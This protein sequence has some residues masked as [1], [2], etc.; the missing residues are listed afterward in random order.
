MGSSTY[1]ILNCSNSDFIQKFITIFTTIF[2]WYIST[3]VCCV[4]VCNLLYRSDIFRWKIYFNIFCWIGWWNI[5]GRLDCIWN[6]IYNIFLVIIGLKKFM[7][8]RFCRNFENFKH[9]VFQWCQ[10]CIGIVWMR[11]LRQRTCDLPVKSAEVGAKDN[12]GGSF[13]C[14]RCNRLK[15]L[16]LNPDVDRKNLTYPNTA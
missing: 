6:S 16:D 9:T 8:T 4:C 5:V 12:A 11:D 1:K 3:L 10:F 2:N 7:K 14:Q 15:W 13:V